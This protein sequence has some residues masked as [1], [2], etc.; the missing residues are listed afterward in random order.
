MGNQLLQESHQGPFVLLAIS[1][2]SS[3]SSSIAV[4]CVKVLFHVPGN[5]ENS[6][7]LHQFDLIQ[8][9][10]RAD[11][12]RSAWSTHTVL[13]AGFWL[14]HVQDF[15][16]DSVT[17]AMTKLF[18]L[19]VSAKKMKFLLCVA[20]STPRVHGITQVRNN[21]PQNNSGNEA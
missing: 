12:L 13:T 21:L 4:P 3:V 20:C 19:G 9:H 8:L 10:A 2:N 5:L 6:S 16:Q 14:V 17:K 18:V 15:C 11:D 1:P 7:G